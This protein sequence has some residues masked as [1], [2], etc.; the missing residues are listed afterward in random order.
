MGSALPPR[1]PKVIDVFFAVSRR[2]TRCSSPLNVVFDGA[3]AAGLAFW[4][5]LMESITAR[6]QL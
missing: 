6:P 5:V 2:E 4:I 1:A 3:F